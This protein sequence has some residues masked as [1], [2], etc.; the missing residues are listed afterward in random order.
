MSH[1]I[2]IEGHSLF[3]KLRREGRLFS[4]WW[5]RD[6]RRWNRLASVETTF[7]E[8]VEVGVVAVNSSE[9]ALSAELERFD[10]TDPQGSMARDHADDDS[11]SLF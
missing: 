10:I 4:A 9:R 2:T 11:G 5:S 3:L 7:A 6:G 1:G 8:R